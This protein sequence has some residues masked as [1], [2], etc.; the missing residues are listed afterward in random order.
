M[1][2]YNARVAMSIGLFTIGILYRWYHGVDAIV[3][4]YA[5]SGFLLWS[6]SKLS[7]RSYGHTIR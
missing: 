7:V 2:V 6:A 5:G 3:S 4:F 1:F